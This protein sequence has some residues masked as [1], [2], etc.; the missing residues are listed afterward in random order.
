MSN[1]VSI[2]ILLGAAQGV[3][4]GLVLLGLP[5]GNRKA[6]RW[7]ALL[8]M[9]FAINM[10]GAALYDMRVTVTYPHLAL[11]GTPFALLISVGFWFFVKN[12]TEK[13][14][15]MRW[16]HWLNFLP[17]VLHELY[18]LP[19]YLKSAEAKRI[20]IESSY[21]VKPDYWVWAFHTSN[22][23]SVIYVF[24]AFALILRHERHIRQLFSNT[25][26]K[27]LRWLVQFIL[28]MVATF[29]ICIV[30]SIFDLAFADSFS[31][32]V[33]SGVIYVMGYRAFKQPEVFKNIPEDVVA[34]TDDA[35]IIHPPVKYEKSGLSEQKAKQLL[36]KL[37]EA[38]QQ[39]HLYLD[40]ELALPQ[41]AEYMGSSTHQVSQLLN[42]HRQE[43]FFDFVNRHRVEHFKRAA[44]DPNNAHLS[45]LA[46]A[47]DSGFNSKA[48]FN[49]VFK[50]MTGKTPSAFRNQ[51]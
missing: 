18:F 43:S 24:F 29:V 19:F 46:V 34:E 27:S 28:A 7:L 12:Y 48:A 51:A 13:N 49:S 30:L 40:Q 37:D 5:N 20:V 16:W 17:F 32:L 25:E 6:N 23:I 47:F 15:R 11:I 38:M 45:I 8:V 14:F 9:S 31:N 10:A 36:K 3:F 35:A 50:K 33:F 2:I 22:F 4:F 41:L 42:Q 26:N 21:S 44:L 39:D 1:T